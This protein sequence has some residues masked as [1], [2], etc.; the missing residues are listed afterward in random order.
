MRIA[1]AILLAGLAAP[2]LAA[3]HRPPEHPATSRTDEPKPLGTFE[4]W[5][6]A[7]HLEGG[8]TVCYAF[9][10]AQNSVPKLPGRGD[11]VLT[12]AERPSGRDAVAISAGY[13]FPPNAEVRMRIDRAEV[14]FYTSQRSAFARNGHAAVSDFRKAS[15]AVL[16]AP[17]PHGHGAVI[18]SFSLR[19][20]KAAY[21]EIT[22]ACPPR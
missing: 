16:R 2:A 13:A 7:Q 8:Q 6:A 5:T 1:L 3:K 4:N 9:T 15:E 18:D 19:G 17:G 11:V 14:E 12:V 22:K 20:F 21:A 10:R